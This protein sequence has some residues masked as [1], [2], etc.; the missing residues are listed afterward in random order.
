MGLNFAKAARLLEA[1]LH[2]GLDG[3][4]SGIQ[5][6]LTLNRPTVHQPDVQ[7]DSLDP[8]APGGPSPL[9]S[10][11]GPYGQP[12]ASDPLMTDPIRPGQPIP[13]V[14]GPDEDTTVLR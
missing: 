11:M 8:A 7:T 10:G 3:L 9:N 12:V 5:S 1:E 2:D 13:H 6:P 14:E 4:P